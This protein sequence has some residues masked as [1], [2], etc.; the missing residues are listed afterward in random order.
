MIE[1]AMIGRAGAV[2]NPAALEGKV[3]L[4]RAIVR[5]TYRAVIVGGCSLRSVSA[6]TNV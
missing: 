5:A 6:T 4:S 1:G 2:G 3:S